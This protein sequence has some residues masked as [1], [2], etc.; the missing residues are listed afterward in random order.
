MARKP[1][2]KQVGFYH[3]INRGV[4]KRYI[5]LDDEDR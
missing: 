1:R 4:E 3:V 5:Y 2:I